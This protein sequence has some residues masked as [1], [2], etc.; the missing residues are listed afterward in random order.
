MQ[1]NAMQLEKGYDLLENF[2]GNLHNLLNTKE[3]K[4]QM[5][6]YSPLFLNFT[7]KLESGATC[8]DFPR[9]CIIIQCGKKLEAL[10]VGP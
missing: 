10:L 2:A 8:D 5:Y 3:Y 1:C 6:V 4:S 7:L 9:L